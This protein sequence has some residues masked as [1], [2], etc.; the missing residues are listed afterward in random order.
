MIKN[1]ISKSIALAA[2]SLAL[3]TASA[4]GATEP[5]WNFGNNGDGTN[6]G[7]TVTAGQ[8]T[9]EG[10]GIEAAQAGGNRAHDAAHPVAVLTSPT[11]N[12]SLVNV[13]GTDFV[14]DIQWEG[15]RG[16]QNNSPDPVDLAA[17]TNYNGGNTNN[18]G[19][20]GLGFRNL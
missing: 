9:N 7:W 18:A 16:N 10:N 11:I 12:F 20:K 6:Q 14:I 8:F 13:S 4:N 1:P 19:Q 5:T 15:G 2:G 17:V 3:V